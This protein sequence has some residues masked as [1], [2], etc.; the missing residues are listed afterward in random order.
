[1]MLELSGDAYIMYN[2]PQSVARE[3]S[4]RRIRREQK[5][6]GTSSNRRH[7]RQCTKDSEAATKTAWFRMME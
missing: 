2:F 7:D 4:L 5:E 1:M 6:S 3:V